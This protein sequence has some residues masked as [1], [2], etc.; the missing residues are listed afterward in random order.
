MGTR[1]LTKFLDENGKSFTCLYRQFDGY[2]EGHGIEL[3]NIISKMSLVNGLPMNQ[4]LEQQRLQANGIHELAA[5]VI[6]TLK[7]SQLGGNFYLYH[8]DTVDAGEEYVYYISPGTNGAIMVECS[9]SSYTNTHKPIDQ[10]KLKWK[11]LFKCNAKNMNRR[12]RELGRK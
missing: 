8:P 2:P 9:A 1:S 7:G 12:I 5:H 4:P 6:A 11:R 10:W 3:A